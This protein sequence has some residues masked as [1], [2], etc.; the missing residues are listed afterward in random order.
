MKT[1]HGN[2]LRKIEK[3]GG[4]VEGDGNSS[5]VATPKKG[6]GK[7]APPAQAETMRRLLRLPRRV[8]RR[9]WPRRLLLIVRT[10]MTFALDSFH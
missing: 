5:V 9:R 7:N 3:A 10:I 2:T 8:V 6:S 1:S 4:K